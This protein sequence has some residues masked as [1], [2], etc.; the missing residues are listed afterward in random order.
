MK[1]KIAILI[2]IA[3]FIFMNE[4]SAEELPKPTFNNSVIIS[5]EHS[6]SDSAV[7]DYIKNNFNFGLYAWLSFSRTSLNPRLDWHTDLSTASENIQSFKNS[8]NSLIAAAKSKNVKLHIVVTSGLGRPQNRLNYVEAKEEDIRNCQWYQDNNIAGDDQI[9]SPDVFTKYVSGTFSRY[10]R[11]LRANLEAKAKAA[12]AFLKQVMDENPDTLIA[13]SGWGEA[14]MNR[15]RLRQ[16]YIVEGFCDYSPFA[17]MEFRDWIQHTGMYDD[18][19]GKYKGEGYA[20]GGTKYQGA[21][22]L[23]RFNQDFD[24]NF[25]TWDLLYFNWSLA[26]DPDDQNPEDY[27]NNDPNILPYVLAYNHGNM[28]PTSGIYYTPGG[29]D[30]PRVR[31]SGDF[32]DLWNLFRETLV[33]NFVK[34]MAKWASEAGIPAEQWYSHQ[35]PGDYMF[36]GTPDNP[37][38][39]YYVSASPLRTADIEPLGS[40]GITMYDVKFGEDNPF[41]LPEFARTSEYG[42]D[43]LAQIASNRAIL[44]YDAEAYPVGLNVEQSSVAFILNE[45]K[46]VYSYSPRLI[47]FWRWLDTAENDSHTIKGFNKEEALRQF[48]EFARGKPRINQN[49]MYTPPKVIDFTVKNQATT[50]A[51]EMTTQSSQSVLIEISGNIWS[52]LPW[53]WEEWSDFKHFEIYRGETEGFTAD[54]NSLLTTTSNTTYEDTSILNG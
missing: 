35:I 47:N 52:D 21:A 36:G 33:L 2:T 43:A 7:V 40:A 32:W 45:Y 50:A 19:N 1:N 9:L 4:A 10:A 14:E 53:K 20:Q 51:L 38:P 12:L 16:G 3:F 29:F 22:G 8:V 46:R 23:S 11:K 48:V 18:T 39:R 6:P 5:I 42:L 49:Q 28:K 30:P 54:S 41:S 26:D 37:N 27:I 17:V 13:V 15:H 25:A 24:T 34:D 44:E 31:N